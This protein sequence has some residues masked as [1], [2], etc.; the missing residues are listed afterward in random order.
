MII[1][2]N[3][4]KSTSE[5]HIQMNAFMKKADEINNSVELLNEQ[6]HNGRLLVVSYCVKEYLNT[7]TYESGMKFFKWSA[8]A[9]IVVFLVMVFLGNITF[10]SAVG[11][12]VLGYIIAS[13]CMTLITGI[14]FMLNLDV[15]SGCV[16]NKLDG[17][18]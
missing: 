3:V 8:L 14:P 4:N 17:V 18:K 9:A 16:L 12:Y 2:Y 11:L 5:V 13:T 6:G 10:L 15:S 1:N 7:K